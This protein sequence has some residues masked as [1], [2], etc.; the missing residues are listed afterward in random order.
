ME[1][2]LVIT[3]FVNDS[4]SH[5]DRKRL[6][7]E[8]ANTVEG[9]D[10]EMTAHYNL[11]PLN[12]NSTTWCISARPVVGDIDTG[13]LLTAERSSFLVIKFFKYYSLPVILIQF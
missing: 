5:Q 11:P 7:R 12:L 8:K 13:N 9:K 2:D 3:L 1:C 10:G 4:A 6:S